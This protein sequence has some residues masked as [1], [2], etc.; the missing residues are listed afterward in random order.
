MRSWSN[1]SKVDETK[2]LVAHMKLQDA[3][4]DH[5]KSDAVNFDVGAHQDID[6]A[7]V[8]RSTYVELKFR[9]MY[10]IRVKSSACGCCMG[11]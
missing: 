4:T 8:A 6:E 9:G 3:K 2:G 11:T 7:R 10:R 5:T 1:N